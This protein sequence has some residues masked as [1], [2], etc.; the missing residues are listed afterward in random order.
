MN[1]KPTFRQSTWNKEEVHLGLLAILKWELGCQAPP[2]RTR[3]LWKQ[4]GCRRYPFPLDMAPRAMNML[5]PFSRIEST[6]SK[7]LESPD[8]GDEV[9]REFNE[10]SAPWQDLR[11]ILDTG[12]LSYR[13][14]AL[15]QLAYAL[16]GETD[17]TLRPRGARSVA[18]K[19]GIFFGSVHI[20]AVVDAYQNIGKNSSS[21]VRGNHQAFDRFL[22]L[23]SQAARTGDTPLLERLF[24]F[25][26]ATVA[27]TARPVLPLPEIDRAKL[28]FPALALFLED[29]LASPS[30]GAYEQFAVAAFL[31]ALLEQ[32]DRSDLRVH[33]KSLNASDQSSGTAGD[34]QILNGTHILEAFEVTANS[35]QEKVPGAVRA[36]KDYDLSRLHILGRVQSVREAAEF[37]YEAGQDITVLPVYETLTTIS[38]MLRKQFRSRALHRLYELLDRQQP[39]VART[40][41]YV[42][43]LQKHALCMRT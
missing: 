21:L 23:I 15:I 37:L 24:E 38:M 22:E 16:S 2:E 41:H 8:H 12:S 28:T 42:S 30:G 7:Y 11:T 14:G 27:L 1:R 39:E 43:L 25:A 26:C 3:T 40:N 31:T 5:D 17:L 18:K 13:D 33:T 36:M 32:A 35:W 20:A 34:V 4:T 29:L 10:T 9:T 6:V 19:V